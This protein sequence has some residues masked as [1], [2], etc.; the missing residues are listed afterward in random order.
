MKKLHL[1]LCFCT[2]LYTA[3]FSQTLIEFLPPDSGHLHPSLRQN[4][5]H[6][7]PT[8]EDSLS[9][10]PEPSDPQTLAMPFESNTNATNQ[11]MPPSVEKFLL[12]DTRINVHPDTQI[13]VT[14]NITVNALHQQIRR[15][16]YRDIPLALTE[17]VTVKSLAMDGA[18]HPFFTEN[19]SGALRINFGNDDYI[20]QGVHTYL[21]TYT[22]DGAI[23]FYKNYDELYWNVT[24]NDWNFVIDKAR[25]SVTLPQGASIQQNG[26]SIYTGSKGA[27]EN[28]ARQVA[29]L[30]FE[31]TRPLAPYEGFTVA[32]P[33]NK[34]FF[35]QP[36]LVKRLLASLSWI[37]LLFASVFILLFVYFVITWYKV[38]RDPDYLAIT[39]YEPPENI[40]PA[41]MQYL[42]D[43]SATN[44]TLAS[45]LISLSM[46]G[47]LKIKPNTSFLST[48]RAEIHYTGKK[49][50]NLPPDEEMVL[51]RL[52]GNG[53]FVLGPS[54]ADKLR[55]V[56]EE[57]KKYFEKESKEY[58]ITNSSYLSFAVILVTILAILPPL[59]F[60]HPE[61]IF[62]NAH[63][64]VFFT[65]FTFPMHKPL[66]KL[67]AATIVT[68]F[69]SVFFIGIS[70]FMSPLFICQSLFIIG[71]WGLSFYSTLIQNVTPKGRD[72]LA[73]IAGFEKYMKI[74][75]PNRFAASDPQ[76]AERIF[77]DYLPY[78]F[79]LGMENKW[80]K[81]F[82]KILSKATI[83]RCTAS[84][85]GTRYV[86]SGLAQSVSRSGGG[87]SH[88]GGCS[89]GGH[90]GGGGGGR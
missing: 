3:A 9:Q 17:K 68:A 15:G 79:A 30:T 26:I 65:A 4:T 47:Y 38:G 51:N 20:P 72:V 86:S 12:F 6:I 44:K 90:G 84:V 78:A 46:K 34:G 45:M 83:E 58:I 41:Y 2:L 25:L 73:Q 87:G 55:K 50:E 61:L 22:F 57:L 56:F 85:G 71:M 19:K 70:G 13:T 77:C 23:D 36:P 14:E 18:T 66:H 8:S 42:H 28:N 48:N 7:S 62:I 21:L 10:E 24:G 67:I 75:E 43:R 76:D 1:F 81:K 27:K 52:L 49:H 53:I 89:G 33:F 54:S 32:I 74:A 40:S 63:F 35:V 29:P 60:K 39:Q 59:M 37:P 82:E 5:E 11:P 31:T 69:Y 80:M 64:S 16:I 88:G